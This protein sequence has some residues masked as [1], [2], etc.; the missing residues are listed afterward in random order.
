[1]DTGMVDRQ[2]WT[3]GARADGTMGRHQP[4]VHRGLCS[5]CSPSCHPQCEPAR[6]HQPLPSLTSHPSP[7]HHPHP[8]SPPAARQ[9]HPALPGRGHAPGP[10][11]LGGHGGAQRAEPRS[12]G[13]LSPRPIPGL[14]RG[15]L[16]RRME[17]RTRSEPSWCWWRWARASQNQ[18]PVRLRSRAGSDTDL[19]SLL[20]A[21]REGTWGPHP[22][23]PS[24]PVPYPRAFPS[25]GGQQPPPPGPLGPPVLP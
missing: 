12:P 23:P 21:G 6:C 15:R 7:R 11:F 22:A 10:P 13:S 2:W 14:P 25:P 24:A 18:S 1:M 16:L 17:A 9:W 5:P 4:C 19:R 8:P 20:V 3:D